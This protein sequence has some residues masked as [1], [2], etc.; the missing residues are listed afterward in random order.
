MA[1]VCH[2]CERPL[3]PDKVRDHYHLTGKFRGA[4]HNQCNLDFQITKTIPIVF[5]NFSGY[6][7]HLLVEELAAT[8]N[9][10]VLS[11]NTEKYI[12]DV[13]FRRY[14]YEIEILKLFSVHGFLVRYISVSFGGISLLEKAVQRRR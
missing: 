9:L 2:I 11:N 1:S 10:Q 3:G 14:R 13:F 6:D 7:G 8:G 12:N 4:A 5:H